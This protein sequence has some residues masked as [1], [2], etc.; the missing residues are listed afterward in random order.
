ME[1]NDLEKKAS[2]VDILIGERIKIRRILMN[3]TQ[4]ELAKH[5][6]ITC[7]QFQKYEKGKNRVSASTLY[8]IAQKLCVPV[9]YFYGSGALDT[10]MSSNVLNDSG[11]SDGFSLDGDNSLETIEL[12]QN[13]YSIKDK[14]I[15]KHIIDLIKDFQ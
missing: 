8:N 11:K 2:E 14:K 10:G 15:R 13:Y 9:G 7:Q 6:N 5:L 1:N 4:N 3:L 12:L